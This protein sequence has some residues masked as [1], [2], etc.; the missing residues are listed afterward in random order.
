MTTEDTPEQRV[1]RARAQGLEPSTA[2]IRALADEALEKARQIE[3]L[4]G[5]LAALLETSHE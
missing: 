5:R 1:R 2:D 3:A 4:M